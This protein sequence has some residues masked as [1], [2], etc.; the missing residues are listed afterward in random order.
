MNKTQTK[1]TNKHKQKHTKQ[2]NKNT[3]TITKT[4]KQTHIT[5]KQKTKA[6]PLKNKLGKKQVAHRITQSE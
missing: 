5:K 4:N 6:P 2:T 1:Q 3:T